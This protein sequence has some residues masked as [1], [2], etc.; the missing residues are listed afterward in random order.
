MM[1]KKGGPTVLPLPPPPSTSWCRYRLSHVCA[2]F[3]LSLGGVG[4]IGALGFFADRDFQKSGSGRN[5][6]LLTRIWII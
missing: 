4:G 1:E 6:T 5:M 3:P 2:F